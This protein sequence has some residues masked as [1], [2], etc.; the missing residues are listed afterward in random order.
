MDINSLYD[1]KLID[2]FGKVKNLSLC[3]CEMVWIR[4]IG[5]DSFG[6]IPWNYAICEV[7]MLDG[8]VQT[9]WIQF[10]GTRKKRIH[11]IDIL[12]TEMV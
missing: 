7:G 8:I 3:S 4:K 9:K 11:S 6:I 1:P 12:K 10:I 2:V 5:C